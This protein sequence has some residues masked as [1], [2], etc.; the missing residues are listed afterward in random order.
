MYVLHFTCRRSVPPAQARTFSTRQTRHAGGAIAPIAPRSS[1][2]LYQP[3][4]PMSLTDNPTGAVQ[5]ELFALGT[6]CARA[7]RRAII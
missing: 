3:S 1:L 2:A 7:Y 5:H 4:C 6:T